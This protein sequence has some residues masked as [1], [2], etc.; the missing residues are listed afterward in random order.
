MGIFSYNAAL[1]YEAPPRAATT[2]SPAVSH[3]DTKR[4]KRPAHSSLA[5]SSFSTRPQT[6]L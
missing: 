6:T 2:I 5:A 1:S 3:R 4:I